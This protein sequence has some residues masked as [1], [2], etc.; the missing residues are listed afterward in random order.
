[1]PPKL[2][3]IPS[4]VRK[5]P[6]KLRLAFQCLTQPFFKWVPPG[7]YY[8][9]LPDMDEVNRRAGQI[10]SDPVP[11]E[12]PG[13]NLRRTEQERLLKE[14]EAFWPDLPFERAQNPRSRYFRPNGAFLFQ[15][16]FT[17]YAMLRKLQPRRVI[18]VG[19]GASS[20][21]MLDT[22]EAKSLKTK[23]TFIEPYPARLLE[24]TRPEDR[25]RYE[26]RQQFIQD[27][28]LEIFAELQRG[29]ILFIDTSHVSKIGSDV[30][31]IFF[32][33]LPLLRAGVYIHFHDI[34]YPFEYPLDWLK[35]GMFWNEAYLLRS[36]LMFNPYFEVRLF[37]NYVNRCLTEYVRKTFPLFLDEAG[38]SIWLEKGE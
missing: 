1:M 23:L 3:H 24:L 37:N 18:E 27:V 5:T 28:P 35:K 30:N 20:A 25:S 31:H 12:I 19:C 36:L 17:L 6:E 22:C 4:Y 33:I 16:A 11:S 21:V 34:W 8:S 15:D 13:I 14:F 7:H 26:L 32:K 29:D 9:P 38:A 10:W 2:K